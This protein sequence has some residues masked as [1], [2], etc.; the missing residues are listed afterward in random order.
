MLGGW[1][2]KQK[3]AEGSFCLFRAASW[4]GP[5]SF[6]R[7]LSI[8][9]SS[10]HGLALA[11]PKPA[12]IFSQPRTLSRFP[13]VALEKRPRRGERHLGRTVREVS[14]NK[15][16]NGR[17]AR[18]SAGR[19]LS[20]FIVMLSAGAFSSALAQ[21]TADSN[22]AGQGKSKLSSGVEAV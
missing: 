6:G 19:L 3:L 20:L 1:I 7:L 16:F 9:Q 5:L 4:V 2:G 18:T 8:A 13:L 11:S 12:A 21:A 10:G 22:A 14:M 15:F 17:T